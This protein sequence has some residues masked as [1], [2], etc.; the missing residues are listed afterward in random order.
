[1][2]SEENLREEYRHGFGDLPDDILIERGE[3]QSGE[4]YR[5]VSPNVAPDVR[6]AADMVSQNTGEN[7]IAYPLKVSSV[8]DTLPI[9]AQP[10]L[11]AGNMVK[12]YDPAGAY[13]WLIQ[14]TPANADNDWASIAWSPE[15]GLF[16]AVAITGVGNRVMTSPDG[17]NWTLRASAADN[18]W[19]SITWSPEF[20]LFAAVAI[21]GVGNR[22]MTS[23]DGVNWTI[24]VSAA[25]NDW[26]SITWS[27]E[28]WLFAAVAMTGVGN[29][30]MTSPDGVNW[31]IQVSAADNDWNA[32]A[33]S[34]ELGL[35]VAV[36]GS[37][38][39]NRVMTSPDGVNWT[40]RAS[41][42][43]NAWNAIAWSPELGL[44][45]AVAGSGVGNRV[46]TSPDGVNWTIRASAANNVWNA[47]TWSPEFRLF[48]ATALTGIDN[49][50]MSSTDG[51]NWT[52]RVNAANNGWT[53]IAW[54]P[55]LRLFVTVAENGVG[56]RAMTSSILADLLFVYTIPDNYIG[57]LKNFKLNIDNIII[58][59]GNNNYLF[60]LLINNSVV[61]NMN[62]IPY[63]QLFGDNILSNVIVASN[64]TLTLKL[65]VNNTTFLPNGNI[66]L[67]GIL[68]LSRGYPPNYEIGSE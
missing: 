56:N 66:S 47:I 5:P 7:L 63:K 38:V 55:E 54:S 48:M 27:P 32:I 46:M 9:N 36:A 12:V 40:I 35:F 60:S 44:F 45:V 3:V 22:V 39:G 23:P 68:L 20:G 62:S 64:A 26:T 8:F 42:A 17:V 53:G 34:P 33:W 11:S 52:S 28:L 49:E 41:A 19:T 25:D 50:I 65:N 58:G 6:S 2:S 51:I 4:L 21:T 14:A 24:Q 31:T 37:G 16:A 67:Q 15:L 59:A 10:F 29:R 61:P 57:I 18:D 43:N 30:V 13:T 1:M